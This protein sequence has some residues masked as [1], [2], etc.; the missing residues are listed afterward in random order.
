MDKERERVATVYVLER[1]RVGHV[2][3]REGLLDV[4]SNAFVLFVGM[5]ERCA[6]RVMHINRKIDG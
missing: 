6:S 5:R 4:V 2:G 3:R 1:D